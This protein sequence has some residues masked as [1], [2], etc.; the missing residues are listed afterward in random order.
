MRQIIRSSRFKA[1]IKR[2]AGSGKHRPDDL[3]DTLERLVK[4]EPLDRKH[5]DHALTGDWNGCRELHIRPDWLLIYRLRPGVL[6]L[7]RTGSHS[8]LFG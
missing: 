8:E 7:F 6:E 5:Q 3:F 2:I 1:D 4:D